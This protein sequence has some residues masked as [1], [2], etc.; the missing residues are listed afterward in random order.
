MRLRRR[1]A[2]LDSGLGGLGVLAAV[3]SIMPDADVMYFADTARVPYGDRPLPQVAEFGR[4]IIAWLLPYE[5]SLIIV[6]SGT[7]CAAFEQV[8]FRCPDVTQLGIVE[9]AAEAAVRCTKNDRIGVV[10]TAATA[11]SGI[12]G[13]RLRAL[14]SDLEVTEVGAPAL[15]PLVEAGAWRTQEARA[16]VDASV[17]PLTAAGCDV[18]ILGCTHF[19]HLERWFRESFRAGVTISDPAVACAAAAAR[20]LADA[21]PGTGRLEF[22]ASGDA[23]LFGRRALA[24]TGIAGIAAR[25]VDPATLSVLGRATPSGTV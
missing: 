18:V 2:M 5:P 10:A 25:H 14:R 22:A 24:L 21:Q 1:I 9:C 19:P 6:A 15:V 23:A 16:A 7:T 11:D 4:Q 13:R 8:D 17:R 3:R 12:F 20:I